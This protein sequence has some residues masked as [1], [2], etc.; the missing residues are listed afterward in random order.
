MKLNVDGAIFKEARKF[1]VVEFCNES[2]SALMAAS[3]AEY[4]EQD[5]DNGCFNYPKRTSTNV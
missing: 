5:I 1:G 3:N 2:E 4:G